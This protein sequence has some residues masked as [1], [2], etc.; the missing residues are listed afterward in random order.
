[1]RKGSVLYVQTL[2]SLTNTSSPKLVAN[3][4]GLSILET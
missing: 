4:A 1:M 2:L 3:L